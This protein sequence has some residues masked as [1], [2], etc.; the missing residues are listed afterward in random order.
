MLLSSV[1]VITCR[2]T[3]LR[4]LAVVAARVV[5][6]CRLRKDWLVVAH[7]FVDGPYV[8]SS[9]AFAGTAPAVRQA[10][11]AVTA[12]ALGFE[13]ITDA[14]AE[15]GTA[16]PTLGAV[17]HIAVHNLAAADGL[18][19]AELRP[20]GDSAAATVA[21]D[22]AADLAARF[23]LPVYL[24]GEAHPEG[25]RLRDLRRRLRYFKTGSLS[26][27]AG[28]S[29]SASGSGSVSG[30]GCG[31]AA[32]LSA[33]DTAAAAA[34]FPCRPDYGPLHPH[35]TKG[36]LCIGAVPPVYNYNIAIHVTC[37]ED[38]DRR[39]T[40]E[41]KAL[42]PGHAATDSASSTSGLAA[43][44]L[45]ACRHIARAVAERTGGLP[46]VEALALPYAVPFADAA[47]ATTACAELACSTSASPGS[48]YASASGPS[49]SAPAPAAVIEV[50]CN[51]LD[52]AKTPPAA[53][54][55]RVKELVDQF[56][57]QAAS[58]AA[59]T[60]PSEASGLARLPIRLSLG[61][62]YTI[63]VTAAQAIAALQRA[64]EDEAAALA[65]LQAWLEARDD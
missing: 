47:A 2:A 52:I 35:P 53:V 34:P 51:L 10:V 12:H 64:E 50:A 9:I 39:G 16:H 49:L 33:A 18:G 44:G 1:Y 3:T 32:T 59:V 15:S 21:R 45:A 30:S 8:R 23:E 57:S 5:S 54:L 13:K 25:L 24:Y 60:T 31:A 58:T 19:R 20:A 37:S 22:V 61:A 38:E 65:P 26:T 17:D 63:G 40:L 55:A 43:A 62:D 7:S 4:E 27:A 36:V 56:N 42:A 11:A 41:G 29:S 6:S 14:E 48:V 46:A 28:S